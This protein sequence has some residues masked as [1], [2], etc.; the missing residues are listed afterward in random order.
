MWGLLIQHLPCRATEVSPES[1]PR[2]ECTSTASW[3]LVLVLVCEK[4]SK[5]VNKVNRMIHGYHPVHTK[6]YSGRKD[7]SK[8]YM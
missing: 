5:T 1:R 7:S 2:T 8:Q 3:C 4:R 6:H